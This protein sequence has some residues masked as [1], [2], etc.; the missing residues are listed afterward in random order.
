[1]GVNIEH[2]INI[3]KISMVLN[4]IEVARYMTC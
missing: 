2:L 4:S 3:S 1:M